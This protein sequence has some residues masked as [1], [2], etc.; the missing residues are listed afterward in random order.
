MEQRIISNRV[1]LQDFIDNSTIWRDI[2][3]ELE[4]WLEDIRDQLENTDGSLSVRILDRLGGNAESVRNLI[5]LPEVLIDI[6]KRES[7][8]K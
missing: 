1:H 7:D 8:L 3:N 6:L 4:A 2:K 5:S